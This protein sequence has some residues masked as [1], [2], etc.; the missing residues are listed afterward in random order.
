MES[1]APD[2]S[3]IREA[4]RALGQGGVV[5][6]PTTGL[7]GLGADAR[8]PKAVERVFAMKR[9]APEKPLLVLVA[10]RGDVAPLVREVPSEAVRLMD[11]LWPGRLTLVLPAAPEFFHLTAGTGALGVRL[12]AHPV[13]RELVREFGGPVT[14]T[15]ANL[16]GGPS[17]SRVV[18]IAPSILEA[19]AVVLDAGALAG[20]AGSTVVEVSGGV[21]ILREGAVSAGDVWGAL[22]L[23]GSCF[24]KEVIA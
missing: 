17:A 16:S 13:A 20:G 8:N 5:V 3:A 15:S 6:F 4:A 11:V 18:D 12:A 23:E 19:A 7:Y 10:E 22:G 21:R 24:S 2:L 1:G 14:G 9:R